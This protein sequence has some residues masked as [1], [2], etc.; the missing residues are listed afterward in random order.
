MMQNGQK[1]TRSQRVAAL[2]LPPGMFDRFVESLQRAEV[3]WRIALCFAAALLMWLMLG[4]WAPPFP[5]RLGYTPRR[6]IDA[7]V[8]FQRIDHEK[9]EEAKNKAAREAVYVYVQDPAPLVQ[10]RA[11][12]K[13]AVA[14]VGAAGN[15]KTLRPK[16]WDEFFPA[17]AGAT[18]VSA[19]NHDDLQRDLQRLHNAV[20]SKDGR[21]NFDKAIDRAFMDI[22]QKGFLTKLDQ[23]ADEGNQTQIEVHQI[24]TTTSTFVPVSDVL[25]G[26]AITQLHNRLTAELG[27]PEIAQVVF[28]WV[29]PKLVNVTATLKRDPDATKRRI[30]EAVNR[31][32]NIYRTYSNGQDTP[33][34]RGDLLAKAGV[35]LAGPSMRLLRLEYLAQLDQLTSGEKLYRSAAL[36]GMFAALFALCGIYI[37]ARN[38][39]LLS[40]FR[41]FAT[42]LGLCVVTVALCKMAGDE[43][44]MTSSEAWLDA[45][46]AWRA[47]LVP[48]L[49]FAMTVAI[50]YHQELA[51]LL[52][53]AMALV[54]VL[55]TGQGLA[56][57]V[58]LLSASATAIFLLG[59][60]RTRSKLI[61]VGLCCGIVAVLTSIGVHLLDGQPWNYFLLREAG[62][63]GICSIAA[64][65]LMTGLLP[66]IEKTFGVLTD[67]SL[68]E[69]GDIAHPLL[70]ELVRRAPGTYN[71]SINVASIAEAAAESIGA[72]GL[73]VRVGAYFHDI[74]KM[75]KPGYFVEN[76]GLEA[77]RHQDLLPAMSTLIIIAHIKDGADL[78]RQH[79]LPQ[80]II[81]FILQHHGTTL[82]EYFYRRANRQSETDPNAAEVDESSYRY[83]GPKPSSKEAAVLMV[84]DAVES[85]SRALVEPA[86]A[87][88]EA[89]VHEIAMKRLLDGQ[90][91]DCGLTLHE[92]QTIKES[93]VK[94]LTAV[95]H[96]RVKYPDQQTA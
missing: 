83:P 86:P 46:D 37:F 47:E 59:R 26:E 67:I 13:N 61:Y 87:R 7:K 28:S 41:R 88:I 42:L 74:G 64:G 76:Q 19:P 27:S 10:L 63:V 48:L 23:T 57:Y 51:L 92:L 20:E 33:D 56:E 69:I 45:G 89:L 40:N 44:W 30:L 50:A 4:G 34:A 12:L 24:G 1:R 9:T 38:R 6:D 14:E 43:A 54:V 18:A 66:F 95:Y 77:D 81:D 2:E 70:Q 79:H 21:T 16:L 71:H 25:S 58:T 52:S 82:V 78:A 17:A 96:G 8:T 68:L 84:A 73:L 49:L 15:L 22:E 55:G 32:G 11:A 65:F 3:L 94:S 60:I 39:P 72:H 35:P 91:D 90:F 31:V 29:K 93:L 53:A 62:R 36:L 75:L 5:Y 85:A 80:P